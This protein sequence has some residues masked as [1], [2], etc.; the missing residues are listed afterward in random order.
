MVLFVAVIVFIWLNPD[1]SLTKPN[2]L[3]YCTIIDVG[4]FKSALAVK[5]PA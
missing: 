5:W 4:D 3:V 1:V 2:C